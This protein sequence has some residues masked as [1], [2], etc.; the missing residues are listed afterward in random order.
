M[1]KII[2]AFLFGV[3]TIASAQDQF[4]TP[5]AKFIY[6]LVTT[7]GVDYFNKNFEAEF[8]KQ[9]YTLDDDMIFINVGEALKSENKTDEAISVLKFG[10]MKWPNIIMLWNGLGEAYIEKGDKKEAKTCFERVL[11]IAPQNERAKIGLKK[12]A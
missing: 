9:G 11:K 12:V 3:S 4:V 10:T 5:Q 6:K 7:K 8:E 2:I 1:R